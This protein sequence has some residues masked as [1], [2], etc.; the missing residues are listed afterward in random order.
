MKFFLRLITCGCFVLT[1]SSCIHS[2]SLEENL[3]DLRTGQAAIVISG[4]TGEYRENNLIFSNKDHSPPCTTN[5]KS[6]LGEGISLSGYSSLNFIPPG[7]Y[8][9]NGFY[10]STYDDRYFTYTVTDN[11]P[12]IF[13]KFSVKGGEV[14][15]IGNFNI[16][17][18]GSKQILRAIRP[19]SYVDTSVS[20]MKRLHPLY[21]NSETNLEKKFTRR[22][23]TLKPEAKMVRD[24]FPVLE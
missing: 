11:A 3:S 1:L 6:A 8:E 16:D 4:C 2:K 12:S 20:V 15:Y 23:V 7:T 5:W 22:L 13:T 10:F 9:F 18:R 21:F 19:T 14:V 24:L 17:A